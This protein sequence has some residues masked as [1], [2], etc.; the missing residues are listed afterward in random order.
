M[1]LASRLKDAR[2]IANLTQEQVAQALELPRTAVVQLEAGNRAVSTLEFAKLAQLYARPISSF[3][4]DSIIL[5][6]KKTRWCARSAPP[7]S[8][9]RIRR[10]K[11]RWARYLG[12]CRAGVEL[13]H[14][15]D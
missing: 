11:P 9:A 14:L 3:F 7:R 10:G 8:K 2:S 5:A 15:L 4:E 13:E 1:T 6:K 12:I